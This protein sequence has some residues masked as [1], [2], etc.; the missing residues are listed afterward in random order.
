MRSLSAYRHTGRRHMMA[1][2]AGL[3]LCLQV[4]APLS[5]MHGGR[6]NSL[7]ALQAALEALC[8]TGGKAPADRPAPALP[9]HDCQI[10][11]TQAV[12]GLGLLPFTLALVVPGG[13]G[14]SDWHQQPLTAPDLIH[15]ADVQPRGPPAARAIV[16][17]NIGPASPL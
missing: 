8:S 7:A 5:P 1:L 3:A 14:Q 9:G 6:I 16:P 13:Y 12:A 4:I 11:I 2:L 10:C 17:G 15:V